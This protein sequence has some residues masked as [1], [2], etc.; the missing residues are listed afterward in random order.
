LVAAIRFRIRAVQQQ[1]SFQIRLIVQGDENEPLPDELALCLFRAVQEALNN[2]QKHAAPSKVEIRL[3]IG[4]EDVCLSIVD[5]GC[6][7]R[8]PNQ[9]ER[10]LD[11]QHFG[12]IGLRERLDLVQGTLEVVSAPGQGTQI[13]IWVPL[14]AAAQEP[15]RKDA[16]HD[17]SFAIAE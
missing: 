12:L 3:A 9:L 14:G 6:G 8:V 4:D 11:E 2:A 17:R 16:L 7:F 5:D 1:A 10:L 13:R 15:Y